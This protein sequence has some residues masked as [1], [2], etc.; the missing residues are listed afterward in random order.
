MKRALLRLA[1]LLE[2]IGFFHWQL[3]LANLRLARDVL[4]P[5]S[6]LHPGVV[7]V[8]LDLTGDGEVTVLSNIVTLT[9]GTLSLDASSDD[10]VLYVHVANISDVEDVRREIKQGFERR[11]RRVFG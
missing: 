2:F 1:Y 3:V 8:P 5:V 7:A 6:R 11:I 10:R 9:P 4:G